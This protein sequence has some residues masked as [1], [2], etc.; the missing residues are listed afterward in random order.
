MATIDSSNNNNGT[1]DDTPSPPGT[2]SEDIYSYNNN[3]NN[4]FVVNGTVYTNGV[5]GPE[6]L[7]RDWSA[8]SIDDVNAATAML[9]LKHGPKVFTE[10]YHNG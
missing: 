4:C 7:S 6:R 9:A 8:D 1:C 3:N 2:P 5:G 10:N